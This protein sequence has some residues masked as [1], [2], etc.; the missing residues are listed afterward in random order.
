MGVDDSGCFSLSV[1][2]SAVETTLIMIISGYQEKGEQGMTFSSGQTFVAAQ[3][4]EP[5]QWLWQTFRIL[6]KN[7]F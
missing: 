6:M 4:F 2:S 1:D 3:T 5:N 7:S